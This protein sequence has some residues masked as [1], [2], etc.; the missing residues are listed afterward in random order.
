MNLGELCQKSSVMVR[1]LYYK[2]GNLVLTSFTPNPRAIVHYHLL[3]SIVEEV[4]LGG[5]TSLNLRGIE[6]EVRS[7]ESESDEL[8]IKSGVPQVSVFGPTLNFL[9]ISNNHK[10]I[11]Y[12]VYNS[13]RPITSYRQN[14]KRT[15]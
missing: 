13:D 6:F 9:F 3:L 1:Y 11:S 2:C 12:L 15:L 10:L 4:G 7:C 8:V 14:V 5:Q